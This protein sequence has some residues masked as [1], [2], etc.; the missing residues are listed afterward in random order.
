MCRERGRNS[1]ENGKCFVEYVIQVRVLWGFIMIMSTL[2]KYEYYANVLH[3]CYYYNN[4]F[5]SYI[6]YILISIIIY[7]TYWCIYRPINGN[8]NTFIYKC[9]IGV[10]VIKTI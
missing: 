5:V 8:K 10:F 2:G 6:S 4:N 7:S 1:Y 3:M 9:A